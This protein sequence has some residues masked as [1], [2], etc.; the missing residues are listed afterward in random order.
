MCSNLHVFQVFEQC[1]NNPI[2]IVPYQPSADLKMF[3]TEGPQQKH[4]EVLLSFSSLERFSSGGNQMT[5]TQLNSYSS[6]CQLQR[7]DT[8]QSSNSGDNRFS[9]EFWFK[10]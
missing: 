9:L 10:E 6:F 5:A 2:V 4:Q 7:I 3:V 8:D 1:F